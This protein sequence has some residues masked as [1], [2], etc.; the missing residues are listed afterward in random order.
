M[1]SETPQLDAML[2]HII[3]GYI[4]MTML[5]QKTK[6][7]PSFLEAFLSVYTNPFSERKLIY[8]RGMW[9]HAQ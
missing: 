8:K 3:L 2:F 9:Y 1:T 6:T 4:Y 5:A 7:L